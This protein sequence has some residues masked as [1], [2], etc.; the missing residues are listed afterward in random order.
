MNKDFF[1]DIIEGD[2]PLSRII[3]LNDEWRNFIVQNYAVILGW[4]RFNKATFIQML[5]MSLFY[6]A[7]EEYLF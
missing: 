1:Y 3:C 5:D 2:V 6:R 4:I 7:F